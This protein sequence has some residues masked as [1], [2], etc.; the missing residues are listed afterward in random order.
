MGAISRDPQT[1]QIQRNIDL[2]AVKLALGQIVT[3]LGILTHKVAEN[4]VVTES[5]LDKVES[6]SESMAATRLELNKL[7]GEITTLKLSQG[8]ATTN[9][10]R[11]TRS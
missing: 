1:E 8:A 5:L 10:A 9:N 2:G 7:R 11:T 4:S 6:L 3:S